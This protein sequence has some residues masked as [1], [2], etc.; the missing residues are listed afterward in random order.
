[1]DPFFSIILDILLGVCFGFGVSEG[2][3]GPGKISLQQRRYTGLWQLGGSG[4][5]GGCRSGKRI[6]PLVNV[7]REQNI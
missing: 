6:P 1:M 7:K 3:G 4:E 2:D 5:G